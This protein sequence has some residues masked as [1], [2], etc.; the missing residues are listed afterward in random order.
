MLVEGGTH[1]P[2]LAGGLVEIRKELGLLVVVV[3]VDA[4]V[5]GYAVA[6]EVQLVCIGHA[7]GLL[8]DTVETADEGVVA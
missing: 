4:V 3:L 7:W 1:E 6:C 8:V 5:P 2:C